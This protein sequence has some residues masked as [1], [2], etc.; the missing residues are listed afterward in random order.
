[1]A[2]FRAQLQLLLPPSKEETKE[3]SIQLLARLLT[4]EAKPLSRIAIDRSLAPCD[5]GFC[6]RLGAHSNLP[7]GL[8]ANPQTEGFFPNLSTLG[9]AVKGNWLSHSYLAL[10]SFGY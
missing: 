7:Q 2:D 1:M 4:R 6:P 8:N 3:L 10:L 9:Q 5:C